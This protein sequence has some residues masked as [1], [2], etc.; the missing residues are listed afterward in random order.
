MNIT[1]N[2]AYHVPFYRNLLFLQCIS[3]S[4]W[5][6]DTME[7]YYVTNGNSI[8]YISLHH[9]KNF[10]RS[11]LE[12]GSPTCGLWLSTGLWP[13][14]HR[15]AGMAGATAS[16]MQALASHSRMCTGTSTATSVY[17]SICAG[18]QVLALPRCAWLCLCMCKFA[19]FSL[20]VWTAKLEMLGASGLE[21]TFICYCSLWNISA[22]LMRA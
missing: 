13:I 22:C 11:C 20:S 3:F 18:M 5:F 14:G 19:C 15:I 4:I 9:I 12:Q 21:K 16:I 8:C 7:I 6:A 17:I 2:L 10:K 1:C